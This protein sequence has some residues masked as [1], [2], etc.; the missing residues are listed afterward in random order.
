MVKN[1]KIICDVFLIKVR[2]AL[3]PLSLE[4]IRHAQTLHRLTSSAFHARGAILMKLS[5]ERGI[6][7]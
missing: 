7:P 2:V 1:L 5:L 4:N 3:I 6:E